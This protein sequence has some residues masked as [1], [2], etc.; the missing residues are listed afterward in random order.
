MIATTRQDIHRAIINN[1]DAEKMISRMINGRSRLAVLCRSLTLLAVAGL[2]VAGGVMSHLDEAAAFHTHERSANG[3][4]TDD[5]HTHLDTGRP[6]L[7]LPTSVV[8]C[9]ADLLSQGGVRAV[10][11]HRTMTNGPNG[12]DITRHLIRSG[13]DPPPP[14]SVS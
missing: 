7:Q 4:H 1:G 3:Q 12:N 5:T 9:G 2:L 10:N 8:H 6:D 14:R 11:W 13:C